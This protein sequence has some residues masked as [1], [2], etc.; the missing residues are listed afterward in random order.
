MLGSV[1]D[2]RVSALSSQSRV[3]PAVGEIARQQISTESTSSGVSSYGGDL[4][5]LRSGL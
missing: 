5:T 2:T 4:M 1:L 3:T